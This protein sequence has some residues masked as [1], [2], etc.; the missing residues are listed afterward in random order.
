MP[1]RKRK[2]ESPQPRV[3][4]APP[5]ARPRWRWQR[6]ADGALAAERIDNHWQRT[7]ATADLYGNTPMLSTGANMRSAASIIAELTSQ[8]HIREF[9]IAPELLQ[10]AWHKAVGDFLSKQAELS[11]LT[12][13]QA[14]V[15]TSHPAVRFELLRRKSDIIRALNAALGEGCVRT[16]RIVHGG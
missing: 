13:G 15:R 16:V 9:E 8:I 7:Q 4:S 3:E 1:P 6:T 11:A 2:Q 12:E 14:I 10:Q 5:Q